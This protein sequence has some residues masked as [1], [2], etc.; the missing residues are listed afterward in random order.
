MGLEGT[1][2]CASPSPP[3]PHPPLPCTA[4][5]CPALPPGRWSIESCRASQRPVSRVC[6]RRGGPPHGARAAGL[7]TLCRPENRRRH[8]DRQWVWGGAI[9]ARP[10]HQ[11]VG[12]YGLLWRCGGKGC[13]AGRDN[14]RAGRTTKRSRAEGRAEHWRARRWGR[15]RPAQAALSPAAARPLRRS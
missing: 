10:Q 1:T 2:K 6:Q 5:H 3:A 4:L 12:R 9:A 13:G 14:M 8:C 11:F 7:S 15:R